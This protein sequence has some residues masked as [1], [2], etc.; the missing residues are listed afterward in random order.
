MKRNINYFRSQTIQKR[1]TERSSMEV[2]NS[3]IEEKLMQQSQALEHLVK[4]VDASGDLI[5]NLI[6]NLSRG[7]EKPRMP[8][9]AEPEEVAINKD[10]NI[11]ENGS[12]NPL[13]RLGKNIPK[14][15]KLAK[16]LILKDMQS[17]TDPTPLL[18]KEVDPPTFLEVSAM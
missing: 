7:I 6:D 12:E 1:E 14:Y 13:V 8:A 3:F 17:G 2:F 15:G 16:D 5:K 18:E 9:K 10:P 11:N 4:K